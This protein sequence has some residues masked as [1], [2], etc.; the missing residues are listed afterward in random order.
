MPR[1]TAWQVA[2]SLDLSLYLPSWSRVLCSADTVLPSTGAQSPEAPYTGPN[3]VGWG[4]ELV[5]KC[6]SQNAPAKAREALFSAG[7]PGWGRGAGAV[8]AGGACFLLKRSITFTRVF[9]RTLGGGQ[10]P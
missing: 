4:W 7:S 1:C 9:S 5:V 2:A 10:L 6:F 8:A 3:V